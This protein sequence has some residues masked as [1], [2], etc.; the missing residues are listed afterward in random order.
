MRGGYKR[1]C[2]GKVSGCEPQLMRGCRVVLM[3]A[4]HG[5]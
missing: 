2:V 4:R 1:K 5:F 3:A